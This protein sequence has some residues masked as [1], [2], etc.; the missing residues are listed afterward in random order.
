MS[1]SVNPRADKVRN[2]IAFAEEDL[3]LARHALLMSDPVPYRHSAFHSQQCAEK[4][5]KAYLVW[6]GVDFPFT[7]SLSRLIELC[8]E[9]GPWARSVP[10]LDTLTPYSVSSRYPGTEVQ[11]S[12]DDANAAIRIA[13]KGLESV[14]AALKQ[15]GFTDDLPLPDAG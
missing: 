6:H 9:L 2:W 3:R 5:L 11:V 1:A 13:A 7:H 14:R 8:L 10:D 4:C 12:S 15:D